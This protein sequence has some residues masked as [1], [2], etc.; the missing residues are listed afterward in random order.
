M[1]SI[2]WQVLPNVMIYGRVAKG[3][4]SGGFNGR[5]NSATERTT[6]DPETVLS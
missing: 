5:A 6:Y 4:K 3:F 2:D 1:A